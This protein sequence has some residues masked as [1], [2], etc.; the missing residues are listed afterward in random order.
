M[1]LVPADRADHPVIDDH[2]VCEAIEALGDPGEV[3]AWAGRFS[4]LSDAGRLALLLCIW[5]A[6]P[7]CVTDLA[8][9]VGMHDTTVSQAL[10]LLR[11]AG[12]VAAERDGRVVRYV[13]AD[14]RILPLLA[15]ARP[16]AGDAL[17]SGG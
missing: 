2:R 4:L 3:A 13:I 8:V 7:I 9:A 16:A 10:R 14:R 11:T 1:H 15:L 17:V 12:V 5:Q 6:G